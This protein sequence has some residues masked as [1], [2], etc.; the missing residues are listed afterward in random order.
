MWSDDDVSR[1]DG[2]MGFDTYSAALSGW[3]KAND[4]LDVRLAASKMMS[5]RDAVEKEA[6]KLEQAKAV[7]EMKK[8]KLTAR[9]AADK[10]KKLEKEAQTKRK[11]I[12][13]ASEK[14]LLT[15][16]L[17]HVT[18][19]R[20][21][22]EL[23]KIQDET[24]ALFQ[25]AS[26][27]KRNPMSV[28]DGLATAEE[29]STPIHK[30]PSTPTP[31]AAG[32][33]RTPAHTPRSDGA[34]GSSGPRGPCTPERMARLEEARR[35]ARDIIADLKDERDALTT[36]LDDAKDA[37]ETE[38]AKRVSLKTAYNNVQA[39][40]ASSQAALASAQAEIAQLKAAAAAASAPAP[41]PFPASTVDERKLTHEIAYLKSIMDA[42]ASVPKL[43]VDVSGSFPPLGGM[44]ASIGAQTYA[45]EKAIVPTNSTTMVEDPEHDSESA[46]IGVPIAGVKKRA[47]MEL[48]YA[49]NT[50]L[51]PGDN[52]L[53][54][55][56]AS[57]CEEMYQV[58]NFIVGEWSRADQYLRNK[59]HPF[60][61]MDMPYDSV[62]YQ[63]HGFIDALYHEGVFVDTGSMY[64]VD[65][66][67]FLTSN[68]WQT[69][70]PKN[71]NLCFED[72]G[73][74]TERVAACIGVY[75]Q[76]VK[77]FGVSRA[78]Y[79]T[80]MV[81]RCKLSCTQMGLFKSNI[82]MCFVF[83]LAGNSVC[84]AIRPSRHAAFV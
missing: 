30:S 66:S 46:N 70:A 19:D 50:L 24:D 49:E 56:V 2:D 79:S 23:Q 77:H 55:A 68:A 57:P 40:L 59:G 27:L 75:M 72:Q 41:A 83:V 52:Y 82:L 44:K 6:A 45:Y 7:D 43:T 17:N 74:V 4:E 81:L 37:F 11:A 80:E 67:K 31:R 9:Q 78:F 15:A 38:R 63:K 39:E 35:R 3:Q 47:F 62:Y 42:V 5:R 12:Q 26:F 64:V 16:D 69:L 54:C 34:A 53:H 58:A 76:A 65:K 60:T 25:N 51:H 84:A 48:S 13:A 32:T 73:R 61:W 20:R 14:R 8:E 22:F 29:L 71:L 36:A 21:E 28:L 10:L 33:R 1:D 18:N